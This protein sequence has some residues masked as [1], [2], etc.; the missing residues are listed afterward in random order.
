MFVRGVSVT[1]EQ[2][3]EGQCV[4]LLSYL[5]HCSKDGLLHIRMDQ[6]ISFLAEMG[7]VCS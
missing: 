2:K 5:W 4:C 7:Q 6:S 3:V 1:L